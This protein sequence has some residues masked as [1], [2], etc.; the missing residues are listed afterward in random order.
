MGKLSIRPRGSDGPL[1]TPQRDWAV[2]YPHMI[3]CI[4]SAF[5]RG[6]WPEVI[7]VVAAAKGSTIDEA[8]E[9]LLKAHEA[10]RT[11]YKMCTEEPSESLDDVLDR[12]GWHSLTQAA[13]CGYLAMLGQVMTGQAFDGLRDVTPVGG[14]SDMVRALDE[15]A[16]SGFEGRRVMNN[17]T[18][19]DDLKVDLAT[20]VRLLRNEQV[21]WRVI[22][23]IVRREMRNEGGWW[24]R[25]PFA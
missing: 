12:C 5:N 21:P 19:G 25:L 20:L 7:E 8:W 13:K 14:M 23:R 10:Y 1:Y 9:E 15:L 3:K 18:K 6:F 24:Q 16:Q 4:A 2:N 17:M 11:F 22:K